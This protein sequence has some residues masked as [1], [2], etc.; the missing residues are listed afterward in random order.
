[1]NPTR[2][3]VVRGAR[4]RRLTQQ[5]G[6]AL[7]MTLIMGVVLASILAGLF[8]YISLSAKIERRSNMRVESTYAAEVATEQAFQ[9]LQTLLSSSTANLPNIAATTG[10]TNL[11]TAPTSQFGSA[12][13]YTWKTFLTVPVE[14]GAV[15]SAHSSFNPTQGVYKFLTIVEFTRNVAGM[16]NPV[17]MQFQ[18]EWAYSLTPLF[19]YAIFYDGDMELFP[20]AAFN[21]T[22]RVHTNGKLYTGTNATLTYNDLV[23]DVNGYSSTYM[24]TD[25]RAPGTLT[26]NTTFNSGNPL[27]TSQLTPPGKLSADTSDANYNNDGPHELI[28]LPNS[29]QSDPDAND[30]MYNKAGVKILVNSTG[31]AVTADS[32]VTIPANSRVYMTSDGT[33]IP[34]SDPLASY[35]ST[36]VS[37]GSIQDYRE[38]ASVTT[39]DVDL[40][41]V[42]NAYSNGGLP[43][44]LPSSGTWPNNGTVP[45]ALKGQ[46]ISTAL[47]G[48]AFWNGTIYVA[49]VTN[50]STHRTGVKLINGSNLPDGS[51]SNSPAKGLTVAT[52]NAAYIVGDYNTGGTPPV[53]TSSNALTSNNYASGYT[54]Q[55]AAV[56]ADAVTVLSGAWSSSNNAST[57]LSSR[58]AQN[59]TINTA[60]IS[61]TVPTD[62]SSYSGGVENYI[63]LG[64]NW[65][66]KRLTYYGSMINLYNSQQST[67]K[68]SGTG[69]YYQAANRNW[70]FDVNFL[71]PNKLPPG[72]PILRTLYRGQW[73][74]VAGQ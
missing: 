6:S 23:T 50:T 27:S 70:Y 22:G 38:N 14:N 44:N 32:G 57:A 69:T 36:L 39:T 37:S 19:Q 54:V 43:Q 60:L 21:V 16:N 46:S 66:G 58:S 47:Q 59:T 73:S 3:T 63:R 28:E 49:D 26:G 15:T 1:M 20:G 30:R 31:T 74:Q 7:L 34:S 45:A 18:R 53:D 48:K 67:G 41:K 64:E 52:L 51:N 5:R 4:P 12:D 10:V 24:T 8:S 11:T 9:Q 62:S 33:V 55:P 71:D 72:T 40:S 13:G 17:H 2:A 56:I 25:P 35:L 61:G 65:S 42:N 68:W 29:W